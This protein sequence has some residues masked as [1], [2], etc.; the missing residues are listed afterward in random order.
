MAGRPGA[1]L[2]F[3]RSRAHTTHLQRCHDSVDQAN[4]DLAWQA[5]RAS[6]SAFRLQSDILFD[7]SMRGAYAIQRDLTMMKADNRGDSHGGQVL[8][9]PPVRLKIQ[10][11]ACQAYDERDVVQ[12]LAHLDFTPR[13]IPC[14]SAES[15]LRSDLHAFTEKLVGIGM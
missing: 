15:G 12:S 2:H 10:L 9:T 4:E 8:I 5:P 6:D 3:L 1:P 11:F 14:G 13:L 7:A